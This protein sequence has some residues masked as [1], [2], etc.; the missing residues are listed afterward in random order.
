M[1]AMTVNA[2]YLWRLVS[3]GHA[4]WSRTARPGAAR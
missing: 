3:P 2:P 4:G 1:D